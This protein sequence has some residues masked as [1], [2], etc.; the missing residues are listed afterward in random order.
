MKYAFVKVFDDWFTNVWQHII[1]DI[2]DLSL[3]CGIVWGLFTYT[4]YFNP[5]PHKNKLHSVRS[6]DLTG[7]S[8][9]P[10]NEIIRSR[11]VFVQY[12]LCYK[13]PHPVGTNDF[14]LNLFVLSSRQ[15]KISIVFTE[16]F[17]TSGKVWID[18]EKN[19]K[20]KV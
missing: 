7:H 6:Q 18:I 8:R 4:F 17:E 9:S 13:L 10:C 19:S 1:N 20:S 2:F 15:D 11:N 12:T 14:E 3:N 5:P 16:L